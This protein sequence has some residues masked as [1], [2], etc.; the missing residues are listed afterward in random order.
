[1]CHQS[2][3]ASFISQPAPGTLAAFPICRECILR[4]SL[5]Y[6]GIVLKFV[7]KEPFVMLRTCGLAGAINKN[8]GLESG[9]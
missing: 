3:N 6:Y 8:R 4:E 5:G 1:M 9:K 7:S 2:I